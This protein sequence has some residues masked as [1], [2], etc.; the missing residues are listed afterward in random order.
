MRRFLIL[1]FASVVTSYGAAAQTSTPEPPTMFF[2]SQ[3][4]GEGLAASGNLA[5]IGDIA[6]PE[7]VP[8][9]PENNSQALFRYAKW[10]LSINIAEEL[11]GPFAPV[12]HHVGLL[13]VVVIALGSIYF[14]VYAVMYLVKWAVW[15]FLI[16]MRIIDFI[17][18]LISRAIELVTP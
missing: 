1:I 11:A 18:G 17:T 4:I 13:L 14:V 10:I 6:A 12:V 8:I 9:L 2:P 7:G 3:S 5:D 15:L 16:A